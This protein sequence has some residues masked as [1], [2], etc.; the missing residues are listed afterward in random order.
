MGRVRD[1]SLAWLKKRA[2]L[3]DERFV[4]TRERRFSASLDGFDLHSR[5]SHGGKRLVPPVALRELDKGT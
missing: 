3:D 4:D 2:Y 1:R 5:S